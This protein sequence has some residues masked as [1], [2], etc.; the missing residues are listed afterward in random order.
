MQETRVQSLCGED[1]LEE[2]KATCSSIFAWRIPW[3]EEPGRLQFMGWQRVMHDCTT[4]QQQHSGPEHERLME[5]VLG[6][7]LWT[8]LTSLLVAELFAVSGN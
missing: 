8:G 5:E 4:K 3:A 2:E 6:R 1:P 7:G